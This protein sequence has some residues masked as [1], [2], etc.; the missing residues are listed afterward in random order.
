[1]DGECIL[2]FKL[3]HQLK[4][5]NNSYPSNH[6]D[7]DIEFIQL[8]SCAVFKKVEI[9]ECI[10][11][12]SLKCFNVA[13]LQ[14]IKSKSRC[15]FFLANTCTIF[16]FENFFILRNI[17]RACWCGQ[18][19]IEGFS[20]IN[21]QSYREYILINLCICYRFNY[22]ASKIELFIIHQINYQ[23][24]SYGI[25]HLKC[26]ESFVLNVQRLLGLCLKN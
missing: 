9:I 12:Q 20:R 26:H 17:R 14:F 6:A 15:G 22:V 19:T 10:K 24:I 25:R 13:K 3:V 7:F 2:E 18:K 4:D 1:M 8:L 16:H 5:M 21:V 23:V 11:K